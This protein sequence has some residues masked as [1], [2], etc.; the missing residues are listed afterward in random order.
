MRFFLILLCTIAA[1]QHA[2]R[3]LSTYER[4]PIEFMRRLYPAYDIGT[5]LLAPKSSWTHGNRVR[6]VNGHIVYNGTKLAANY[7]E[8]TYG[9]TTTPTDCTLEECGADD[10]L[11]YACV[12]DEVTIEYLFG[13]HLIDVN[14]V[15]F[16]KNT[17]DACSEIGCTTQTQ[18]T[19]SNWSRVL[20]S[21]VF[22]ATVVNPSPPAARVMYTFTF[23]APA[24]ESIQIESI[25]DAC[26]TG[27]ANNIYIE[28]TPAATSFSFSTSAHWTIINISLTPN[29]SVAPPTL[30]RGPCFACEC[31]TSRALSPLCDYSEPIVTVCNTSPICAHIQYFT[32][33]RFSVDTNGQSITL[34]DYAGESFTMVVR[35]R[36]DGFYA[37]GPIGKRKSLYLTALGGLVTN[38]MNAERSILVARQ[39]FSINGTTVSVHGNFPVPDHIR[40][41]NPYTL[42]TRCMILVTRYWPAGVNTITVMPCRIHGLM[43]CIVDI[44]GAIPNCTNFDIGPPEVM[45]PIY[46]VQYYPIAPLVLWPVNITDIASSIK[47]ALIEGQQRCVVMERIWIRP[48]EKKSPTF[49]TNSLSP[50]ILA[51][52]VCFKADP[53][54][55]LLGN[56]DFYL[57]GTMLLLKR[58]H[59]KCMARNACKV[60]LQKSRARQTLSPNASY[61]GI[62]CNDVNADARLKTMRD[63]ITVSTRICHYPE[64]AAATF[65]Q[66][67]AW[68]LLA[69]D[70]T[71]GLYLSGA[72]NHM[73]VHSVVI[74]TSPDTIPYF[75]V[76]INGSTWIEVKT[77][78]NETIR[79][80]FTRQGSFAY[81]YVTPNTTYQIGIPPLS[82]ITN[83]MPVIPTLFAAAVPCDAS[84]CIHY[85]KRAKEAVKCNFD[86]VTYMPKMKNITTLPGTKSFIRTSFTS[87]TM[88]GRCDAVQGV[89]LNSSYLYN[90]IQYGL[91]IP[92]LNESFK[93]SLLSLLPKPPPNITVCANV[94]YTPDQ[95]WPIPTPCGDFSNI[96]VCSAGSACIVSDPNMVL[97]G[98]YA[99][100]TSSWRGFNVNKIYPSYTAFPSNVIVPPTYTGFIGFLQKMQC[101]SSIVLSAACETGFACPK[102]TYHGNRQKMPPSSI[103]AVTNNVKLT[104]TGP[105]MLMTYTSACKVPISAQACTLTSA[106]SLVVPQGEL[107]P[108]N[109]AQLLSCPRVRVY[110][111]NN[112]SDTVNGTSAFNIKLVPSLRTM[113]NYSAHTSSATLRQSIINAPELQ[114]IASFINASSVTAF[115]ANLTRIQEILEGLRIEYTYNNA[116]EI[117]CAAGRGWNCISA[118]INKYFSIAGF[119][120][121]QNTNG[122]RPNAVINIP[123]PLPWNGLNSF[124]YLSGYTVLL[125]TNAMNWSHFLTADFIQGQFS[126]CQ[127]QAYPAPFQWIDPSLVY[128][129]ISPGYY[130]NDT[131]LAIFD[132]INSPFVVPDVDRQ[133]AADADSRMPLFYPHD[134]FDVGTYDG[135]SSPTYV[136]CELGYGDIPKGKMIL[137]P[138]ALPTSLGQV[139]WSPGVVPSTPICSQMDMMVYTFPYTLKYPVIMEMVIHAFAHLMFSDALWELIPDAVQCN[140]SIATVE[141]IVMATMECNNIYSALSEGPSSE[142]GFSSVNICDNPNITMTTDPQKSPL[143]AILLASM[144]K[145]VCNQDQM[146]ISGRWG[147]NQELTMNMINELCM[148][149]YQSFFVRPVNS[150]FSIG[151]PDT[152]CNMGVR[153]ITYPAPSNIAGSDP[154]DAY[155]K[156]LL[157]CFYRMISLQGQFESAFQ[158]DGLCNSFIPNATIPENSS[159]YSSECIAETDTESIIFSKDAINISLFSTPQSFLSYS[160]TVMSC[161]D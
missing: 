102:C 90:T 30:Q 106:T 91:A 154:G 105:V 61:A 64:L 96:T 148:I 20:A 126:V 73:S 12:C 79:T 51:D 78:A 160:D 1:A 8:S 50:T 94:R 35:D 70:N 29:I 67:S 23:R 65:P 15:A 133:C 119:T 138:A 18:L 76:R 142:Y 158:F 134:T 101:A 129:A 100:T 26:L 149:D 140:T 99:C 95:W 42:A 47:T 5:C 150:N 137:E 156:G 59:T 22:R 110:P 130:P 43:E 122:V 92:S 3:G 66:I 82:D 7:C 80:E 56:S 27:P 48:G 55:L 2:L 77:N 45:R 41:L 53:S 75:Y 128:T 62:L 111:L 32:D 152:S 36:R 33:T 116:A 155:R 6:H 151:V 10:Y 153:C 121:S 81:I 13:H 139:Y 103:I 88:I 132:I 16:C 98:C 123:S 9:C 97:G 144:Q 124:G 46:S 157:A 38:D 19:I 141:S 11:G 68:S 57:N 131:A 34:D 120:R 159:V 31:N 145:G 161:E 40:S 72:Y 37:Y 118:L 28:K 58:D 108:A 21:A 63:Q 4:P 107:T 17:T 143:C 71:T 25:D 113:C 109:L 125:Q 86:T 52:S 117:E 146:F 85:C 112:Q 135:H 24:P 54:T 84:G 89:R 49:I 14:A 115:F 127:K 93:N 136:Q 83:I 87:S 39:S 74:A 147:L 104:F 69:L 44:P 114:G 60:V